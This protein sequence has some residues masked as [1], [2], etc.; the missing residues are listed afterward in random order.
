M[1]KTKTFYNNLLL[2][3]LILSLSSTLKCADNVRF[4]ELKQ[5]SS[6]DVP[7]NISQIACFDEN[8]V[9]V[10]LRKS[11]TVS[12]KYS[13]SMNPNSM[14]DGQLIP[15]PHPQSF[16]SGNSTGDW[17]RIDLGGTFTVKKCTIYSRSDCCQHRMIGSELKLKD[18]HQNSIETQKIT[19]GLNS[20]EV[21]F[22]G[23]DNA[24]IRYVK[25]EAPSSGDHPINISQ[26]A[27]FNEAGHNVALNKSVTASSKYSTSMNPN[28]ITD[29]VLK[30]RPHPQ[31]FHSGASTNDWLQI[32]LGGDY[33]IKRCE[34]YNRSDCCQFRLIS[35]RLIFM[36]ANMNVRKSINIEKGEN[37]V[38]IVVDEN[39]GSGSD[40]K[41]RFI[42]LQMPSSGDHYINIS[43]IACFDTSNNNVAKGK[44]ATSSTKY[45]ND[46]NPNNLLDGSLVARPH[47]QGFTSGRAS[48]DWVL[49]NLGS[50]HLIDHCV[51]YNRSD[52]C[53]NRLIDATLSLLDA[54]Q[55][56]F[57]SKKITE[58]TSS[59][60]VSFQS[61]ST[62]FVELQMPSSGDH[63]INISQIVCYDVTGK[64][65][66]QEKTV[67]ASSK[68]TNEQNPN[69]LTDGS[70]I[71]RPYPSG[72]TSKNPTGDWVRINLGND[73]QIDKCVIYNRSDCCGNRING[74]SLRLL[75]K[76]E[77]LLTAKKI[78]GQG[79]S[80]E[81]DFAN[82]E[83]FQ[84]ISYL[85]LKMPENG[86]NPMNLS[87]IACFDSSNNNVVKGKPI[88]A[89][90]AS[91]SE[92]A[93]KLVDGHL[94]A[95]PHPQSYHSVNNVNDWVRINLDGNYEIV[96]CR[97]YNRSDCCQNRVIGAKF[98]FLDS[99]LVVQKSVTISSQ[100]NQI[101]INY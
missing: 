83:K 30:E 43:Q 6:G 86:A 7:M 15:R 81:V 39:S 62:R 34:I 78:E 87:Q 67:T 20:V 4:I 8:G 2:I 60:K 79:S 1:N 26:I 49:I 37:K 35:N 53:G 40:Q 47:P 99:Q 13:T 52:C 54:S 72:F 12:S 70:L 61:M 14:T 75:D 85:E 41:A 100:A 88:T 45:T 21:N 91:S 82:A 44:T 11:V 36:D 5:A 69:S 23:Y 10:A 25:L 32:N 95:R 18:A 16:H 28:S 51:I 27:C 80:V 76:S 33:H 68:Y 42:K 19:Q 71:A 9:N 90:P 38:E 93:K 94:G 65:V 74:A 64:N 73:Y 59:V 17:A 56:E 89:A 22:P 84:G 57:Q 50:D 46:Q 66:S 101:D 98:S 96:Y 29:G 92:D 31:S 3:V 48:G 97:I 63:Y 77:S 55:K 58:G 24:L